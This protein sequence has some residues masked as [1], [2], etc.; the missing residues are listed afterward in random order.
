MGGREGE[1]QRSMVGRG[2]S[3]GQWVGRGGEEEGAMDGE[4]R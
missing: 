1:E 4:R 2:N 3:R